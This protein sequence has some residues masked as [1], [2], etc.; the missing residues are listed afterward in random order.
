MKTN[1]IKLPIEDLAYIAGFL[2]GDGSI[3]AQIIRGK[4]YRY[5][6]TVR[7]SIV[8]FQKKK[9]F[10]FI[11]WLKAR[12]GVGYTRLR[13]DLIGEYVITGLNDVEQVVTLI[14]PYLKIKKEVGNLVLKAIS[15]KRVI[16]SK[17]DFLILCT[18]VDKIVALTDGKSRTLN[19][20]V[21]EKF[22]SSP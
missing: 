10:W 20:E 14:L 2:D 6:F 1:N 4:Q 9:R 8:F 7:F 21:V 16:K 13:S 3:F 12:L 22:L 11:L 18:L 15:L 19:K 17:E 5:G